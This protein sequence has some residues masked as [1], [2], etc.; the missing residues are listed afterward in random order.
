MFCLRLIGFLPVAR[1]VRFRNLYGGDLIF[2]AVGGPVGV[3]GGDDV[4]LRHR[5]VE[6][7]VDN[8]WRHPIGHLRAQ[9]RLARTALE[10][11]P[12]AIAK[13]AVLRVVR[14]DFEPIFGMP[15]RSEERGVG[16]EC[17]STCRSRWSPYH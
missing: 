9:R 4:G 7:G 6:S 17:V 16:K 13:A 11:Y 2:G 1:S 5:M 8:A 15:C 14:M 3:I 12:V 10:A